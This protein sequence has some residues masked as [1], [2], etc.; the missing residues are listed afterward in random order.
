MKNKDEKTD[1]SELSINHDTLKNKL[2]CSR[3]LSELSDRVKKNEISK[4][5]YLVNV[6]FI[7]DHMLKNKKEFGLS[8]KEINSINQMQFVTKTTIRMFGM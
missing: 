4:K 5:H 7:T 3:K 2:D 8:Q 6:M 1:K